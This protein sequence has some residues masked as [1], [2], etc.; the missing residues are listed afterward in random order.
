MTDS[1]YDEIPCP[2]RDTCTIKHQRLNKAKW[3]AHNENPNKAAVGKR[4][5]ELAAIQI[6]YLYLAPYGCFGDRQIVSDD[7]EV[8]IT[9]D[10]KKHFGGRGPVIYVDDKFLN[11]VPHVLV[12]EL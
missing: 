12:D 6:Y 11:T 5:L 10:P 1:Y 4:L 9:T 2:F 8:I 7:G 3:K